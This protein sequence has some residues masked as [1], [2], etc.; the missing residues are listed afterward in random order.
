MW[1]VAALVVVGGVYLLFFHHS[2]TRDTATGP[3]MAEGVVREVN[4]DQVAFDG[5]ALIT[6]QTEKDGERVIA[7]PSMGLPL[8]AAF[9]HIA[10]PFALEVGDNVEVKGAEDEEGRIVPCES[11]EH[12]LRAEGVVRDTTIGYRFTYPKGP[13][14]YVL[15]SDT[16]TTHADFV[17]GVILFDRAE[18]EEFLRATDA[19]EGPPAM[20]VRV[21]ENTQNLDAPVWT[22]RN[23]NESNVHLAFGE[24]EETTLAGANA[25]RY[26]ADGL[27]PTDTYVVA[28]HGYIFVLM[29]SYFDRESALYKDFQDLVRSFTFT[30]TAQQN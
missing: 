8:C 10:D 25:V 4:L 11:A 2:G 1:V 7:V 3:G 20:H 15:V 16:E 23:Q 30:Q 22:D 19:R 24:P 14:G 27:F 13:S 18:Y 5:P 29:G 12:Y 28:S 17:S 21:Y 9:S 6:I 26:T